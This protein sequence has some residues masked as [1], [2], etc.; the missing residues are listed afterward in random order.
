[1]ASV[2]LSNIANVVGNMEIQLITLMI[3][4]LFLVSVL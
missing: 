2:K 4:P 1:M 3:I